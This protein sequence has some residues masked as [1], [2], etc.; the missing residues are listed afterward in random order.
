MRKR[1]RLFC[2]LL[3]VVLIGLAGTSA[4]QESLVDWTTIFNS[5]GSVM[6]SGNGFDAVFLEDKISA[7]VG[8]DMTALDSAT[9]YVING[10]VKT[11]HDLGNG[12]VLASRD[13]SGNLLLYAAAE[14][15]NSEA[16]TFVEIEFNQGKVG[17]IPGNPWPIY[18][19]RTVNDIKVSFN[20]IAGNLTSVSI[21]TWNGSSFDSQSYAVSSQAG[22]SILSAST[23]FC[24]GTPPAGLPMANA[25]VWDADYKA[26]Q[27]PSADSF[28]E[29]FINVGNLLGSNVEYSSIVMMTPE[30]IVLGSF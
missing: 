7:D 4:A 8:T 12:Y 15:I 19:K 21:G 25:E 6:N 30:D 22:C 29:I 23:D 2:S 9:G 10:P 24:N 14:R 18:G 3:I 16:N 20:Y 26:V 28:L 13:A 17:L 11:A 1:V 5:E 27:V